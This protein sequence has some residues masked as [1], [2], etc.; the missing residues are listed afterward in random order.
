M[1]DLDGEKRSKH[2]IV[3]GLKEERD[4][5]DLDKF[6]DIVNVVGLNPAV[7][8]KVENIVRLGT[9]DENEQN[10]I[11]PIKVTLETMQMRNDVLKKASKLKDQEEGSVYRKVF[12]K[13]DTHPDVRAEEK[14][15]YEVFKAE[16]DK[17]ENAGKEVLFDRKA[18]VV[19][20]NKEEV[21]RFR[22]FTSFR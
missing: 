4:V 2:I 10:R 8:I 14:R 17:P 16:R 22:L 6:N 12:L 7:D 5:A 3:L 18:R 19:T 20:V 21:D 9:R 15:L 11:R 1:E 13:R